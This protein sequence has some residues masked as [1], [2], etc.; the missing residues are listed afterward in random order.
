MSEIIRSFV[1]IILFTSV[2]MGTYYFVS[3]GQYIDEQ[4]TGYQSEIIRQVG[5]KL[6]YYLESVHI[7]E[8]QL[9]GTVV[10]QNLFQKNRQRLDDSTPGEHVRSVEDELKNV[11][12]TSPCIS[13]IFLIGAT[14]DEFY[15]SSSYFVKER[16]TGKDWFQ[17]F[18]ASDANGMVVPTHQADYRVVYGSG[19]WVISFLKKITNPKDAKTIIGVIQI[20]MDYAKIRHVVENIRID[21][22]NAFFILDERHAALQPGRADGEAAGAGPGG[23][24]AWT[25]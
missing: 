23:G 1:M 5:E 15:T 19:P 3:L 10:Q 7:S 18:M 16:L 22:E 13:D 25:P 8:R 12:R 14:R 21:D 11:R 6:D 9:L 17:R 2:A 4:V 20:D 24:K